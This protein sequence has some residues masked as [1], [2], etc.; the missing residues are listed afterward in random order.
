ML[1]LDA[2]VKAKNTR[3]V[4]G[5]DYEPEWEEMAA[6]SEKQLKIWI[7]DTVD[8]AA[9]FVA[10]LKGNLAFF[11]FSETYR[12]VMKHIYEYAALAHPDLVRILDVKRGDIGNTQS[13]WAAADKGNF[14]PDI[15]TINPYM[16]W[17]DTIVPYLN[18]GMDVFAL[19]STSNKDT[20][21]QDMWANGMRVY[22]R[23]ALNVRR[24]D[25]RRV[26][27]VVGST[28]PESARN[29]RAAEL[30]RGYA[31]ENTAWMLMPGFGRQGG[32]L[33]SVKFAGP[34]AVYP[35]SSGLMSEKYLKGRS[36][37]EAAKD[38]RDAINAASATY[39]M[40]PLSDIFVDDMLKHGI[41]KFAKT[42]KSDAECDWF[43]LKNGT[44]SPLYWDVR[45]IQSYPELLKTAAYL[46][47]EKVREDP[48]ITHISPVPYGALGLGYAVAD[49][50]NK[51]VLTLRKEG[52]KDHG[53]KA[54]IVGRFE[55]KK[56]R[57]AIIEDVATSG[58][59]TME[60]ATPL[61]GMGIAAEDVVVLIDREQ[62]AGDNL[63]KE[64]VYLDSVFTQMDAI[65]SANPPAYVMK[66]L[67][68]NVRQG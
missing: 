14:N 54:E 23:M 11:E 59:S 5:L 55:P 22:Q 44:M 26:G 40:K 36:P 25:V 53:D 67:E 61:R 65:K 13:R 3:V 45:A 7:T 6:K 63:V 52:A 49:Y 66:Y 30:Q 24:A 50:T 68:E 8:A 1:K 10:G 32:D 51:P 16:G 21:I 39:D 41:L 33:A 34:N 42:D 46:M 43:M 4:L 37:A 48:G 17:S 31:P 58:K 19:V 64:N 15:V 60:T 57:A 47:A 20:E 56:T 28:K 2:E 9:P 27:F 35:I 18:E 12:N 62:G 38:W 29:I